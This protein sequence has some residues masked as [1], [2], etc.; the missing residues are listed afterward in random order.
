MDTATQTNTTTPAGELKT[1]AIRLRCDHRFPV[2][3]PHGSLARPGSCSHCGMPWANAAALPPDALREPL[4][5]LLEEIADQYDA[6][7]CDDQAGACNGCE[8]RDDFVAAQL[9][10]QVINGGTQ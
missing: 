7:P 1:A 2:Q 6:P 8:R 10:A 9:V 3:P 4:A 5:A